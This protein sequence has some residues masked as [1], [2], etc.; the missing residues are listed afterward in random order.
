MTRR[1]FIDSSVIIEATKGNQ[2]AYELLSNFSSEDLCISSTVF[3]E[4]IYIFIREKTRLSTEELR[5]SPEK[6][7]KVILSDIMDLLL[8]CEVLAEDEEVVELAFRYIER[9][10]LLPNDALI[11]AT[12]KLNGC[13]LLTLDK[14]LAETAKKEGM[15]VTP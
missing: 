3:S 5:R 15:E 14:I 11:L 12:V 9:Y 13:T 10:G 4:V 8:S 6:V 2:K 1:I 7:K